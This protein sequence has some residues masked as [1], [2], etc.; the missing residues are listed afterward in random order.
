[1]SEPHLP[2]PSPPTSAD[3]G[4]AAPSRRSVLKVIQIVVT[5][6]AFAYLFQATDWN[7]VQRA[8]SRASLSAFLGACAIYYVAIALG[9]VR[10]RLLLTALG[11]ERP[12]PLSRLFRLYVIGQFYNTY[13][14]GGVGGDFVR[15]FAIRDVFGRRGAAG[16][17]ATVMVERAMGLGGMFFVVATTTFF[18]PLEV[19]EGLAWVG[20]VGV[21]LALG[22]FAGLAFARRV[23]SHLP[24]RLG[25]LLGRLPVLTKF[26]P[27][28]PAILTAISTHVLTAYAGHLLITAVDPS[29]ELTESLTLVP[30]ALASAYLPISVGGLGVVEAALVQ[31]L[32]MVGVPEGDAFVAAIMLRLCQ[33]AVSAPGGLLVL[34]DSSAR[35]KVEPSEVSETAPKRSGF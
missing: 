3:V 5:L 13:V 31:M 6:G 17:L 11:A 35:P 25:A 2:P 23:A 9:T 4:G 22:G 14:P 24:E 1:M 32:G 8:Y 16:S 33:W 21:L 27:V 19:A 28:P 18:F 12:V 7:S 34:F 26:W 20:A 30:L 10:W 29:V 15:G